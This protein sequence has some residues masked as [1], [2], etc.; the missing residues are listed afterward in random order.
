MKIDDENR[1]RGAKWYT[2]TGAKEGVN[3][4][5]NQDHVQ[6]SDRDPTGMIE[7]IVQNRERL[8]SI[9]RYMGSDRT[10]GICSPRLEKR[11]GREYVRGYR[12]SGE[13]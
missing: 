8:R 13:G 10:S 3:K 11:K 6:N 4:G 7:N 9:H 5:R 12:L 1:K 2:V